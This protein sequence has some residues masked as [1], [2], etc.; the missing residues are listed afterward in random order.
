[1]AQ[2]KAE[3]GVTLY[4]ESAGTGAPVVFVHELAG[5]LRSFAPQ[6][7][8]LSKLFRCVA[9][10]ARGYPPS[11]VPPNFES[12]SQDIAA[13]DIGAVLDAAGIDQAHVMGVSMGAAACLQFALKEP[14]RVRSA[15]LCSIGSGSDEAPGA[16]AV[17]TEARA[18]TIEQGSMAQAAE[19]FG[20]SP[21]RRKL[22]EKNPALY[23]SYIKEISTLSVLGLT[24]TMRGVQSRRPSL[25]AHHDAIASMRTPT[26]VLVGAEDEPCLKPAR[27]LA[28]T[29]PGVR[30]ETLANT[31]HGLNLEE[32][33]LVNDLITRFID[34]EESRR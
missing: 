29:L 32:P 22:K 14:H 13:A 16:Y 30:L 3:D 25:Y 4:Y 8:V 26:L 20:N 24:N 6:I 28:D 7:D 15:I 27:F 10:N 23:E 19:N 11:E 34:A 2:A 9:Y 12:Y 18:R 33:V 17:E 31:G 21:T 1:M 5:T